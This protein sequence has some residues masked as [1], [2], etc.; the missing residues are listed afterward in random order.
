[1]DSKVEHPKTWYSSPYNIPAS[2]LDKPFKIYNTHKPGKIPDYI[3]KKK[4]KDKLLSG[5]T[6]T[7]TSTNTNTRTTPCACVSVKSE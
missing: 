3:L 4:Q 5:N 6:N 1:M 7:K 2:K